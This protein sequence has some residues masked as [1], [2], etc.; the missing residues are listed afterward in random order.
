MVELIVNDKKI[1]LP[2]NTSIKYTKQI[3][4][5]FDLS[6]IS[7]SYTNSFEFE[8]TPSN[9]QAMQQL[10]ISGDQSLIPYQRNNAQLKSDGFDLISKGWFNVINT[11]DNY[12]GSIIDGMIDFFKAIENKTMGNDLD[13]RNFEH[14]KTLESVIDSFTNQYYNY[15]VADYGGKV[16]FENGI[17]IDYLAPCFSV[18][19]LWELIFSTYGFNCDY[20]NLSYLDGLYITYPKDLSSDVITTEVVDM[21]RNGYVSNSRVVSGWYCYPVSNYYWSSISLTEGVVLDN[22]V[23]ILPEN[24]SY[25]IHLE[26]AMYAVYRRNNFYD[27]K[28]DVSVYVLKNGVKIGSL[29][30]DF[31]ESNVVGDLRILDLNIAG[32]SGDR[33][34][35][36]IEALNGTNFRDR[37]FTFK[38]W[39]HNNSN[40][41]VSKT[42]LGTTTLQNELKDFLI[43][44]FFKEIVWRIGLTPLLNTETNTVEFLN[45]DSRIDFNNSQDLSG[46]YVKRTGEIYKNDYAQKNIFKLKKNVDTDLTGDGYLYVPNFNLSDEK[47]IVQSKLYAPDKKILTSFGDFST[48]QYR[49]WEAETK[50]NNDNEIEVNYKGLSGRFYFIRKETKLG[51][52]KIISEILDGEEVVSSIPVGVNNN[53][54]FEEAVFNNYSEYQKIFQNFRIHTIEL[55]MNI[56]NFIGLDLNKPVFFKQENAFYICNK[57]PYEEGK[58][59]TGEF[60]KINKL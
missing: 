42:N 12:K 22:W 5:I 35:I 8:K 40:L 3:S 24:T 45:L 2:R 9:S 55:A 56:N 36:N 18:R 4:D 31:K 49:I 19:K 13:L 11:E 47:T 50:I 57:V 17:N 30:S 20:T 53:T 33:I 28:V 1:E 21:A 34:E 41:K 7:C 25:N 38:E 37:Y 6:Q 54:L 52:Y 26:I 44:D 29:I 14:A 10:G 51:S 23:Y 16:L 39:R 27:R 59:S 48:N 60:I 58:N 15:I 46:C 32:D 43:K